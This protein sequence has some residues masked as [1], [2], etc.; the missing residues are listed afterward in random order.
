[1][2]RVRIVVFLFLALHFPA[3]GQLTYHMTSLSLL[4][5]EDLDEYI[6][7]RWLSE[8]AESIIDNG[9]YLFIRGD[10][11][12]TSNHEIEVD[13]SAKLIVSY[14]FKGQLYQV[15][16]FPINYLG[17]YSIEGVYPPG[18]AITADFGTFLFAGTSLDLLNRK[19]GNIRRCINIRR[20]KRLAKI[21]HQIL[22]TISIDVIQ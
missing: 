11:I 10:I 16:Q 5:V 9:P 22:P 12:N 15:E 21:A 7:K 1:M 19:K 13:A 18:L 2:V 6:L 8:D 3:F 14:T 4:T 20:G 17:F